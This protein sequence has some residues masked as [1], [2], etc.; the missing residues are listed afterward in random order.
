MELSGWGI[1]ILILFTGMIAG[2]WSNI[3][4]VKMAM[5]HKLRNLDQIASR[6]G[7]QCLKKLLQWMIIVY[8]I[9]ACTGFQIILGELVYIVAF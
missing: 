3:L 1:G 5:K 2:M 9:G 4:I 7:G 8:M 6:A